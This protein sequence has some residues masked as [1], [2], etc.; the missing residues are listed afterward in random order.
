[1]PKTRCEQGFSLLE[2]LVALS[3]LGVAMLLTLSLLMQ[4]PRTLRRLGAHEEVLRVL[5]LTLEGIRAGRSVPEG[6]QALDLAAL[7]VPE[8]S[9]AQDL[10]IWS[11]RV[12]ESPFG[13][14]RL[15]LDARY[16]VG[17]DWFQRSLETRVWEPPRP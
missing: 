16:R 8:D 15:T 4:E 10:R 12:E 3:L 2:T 1:M 5:E 6:R 7:Y 17:P 14:Y 13:L 11:E 9:V